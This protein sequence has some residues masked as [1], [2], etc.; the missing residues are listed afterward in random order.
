MSSE[1]ARLRTNIFV[2]RLCA[3][4]IQDLHDAFGHRDPHR[5][6]L[7]H[8]RRTLNTVPTA[9]YGH[10]RLPACGR[11]AIYRAQPRKRRFAARSK[12]DEAAGRLKTLP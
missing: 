2:A 9:R 3:T 5:R 8:P 12:D 7:F 6:R 4:A 1:L 10:A 11:A